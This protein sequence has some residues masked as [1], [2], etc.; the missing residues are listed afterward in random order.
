VHKSSQSQFSMPRYP[1]GRI[2][3]HGH[4]INSGKLKHEDKIVLQSDRSRS[5]TSEI[6]NTGRV[7]QSNHVNSKALMP[8][9]SMML[10]ASFPTE[11]VFRF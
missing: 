6:I 7:R 4:N 11:G 3:Y 10:I 9:M 5:W 2:Q 8:P 1:D